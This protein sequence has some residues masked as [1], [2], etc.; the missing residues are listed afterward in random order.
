MVGESATSERAG[1]PD[2]GNWMA[3][4]II[5][6]ALFLGLIFLALSLLL[7]WLI[8]IAAVFFLISAYCQY[9]RY[10]L[11]PSGGDLQ[12]KIRSEVMDRLDWD[13]EGKALDIGC[14]AGALTVDL[15]KKYPR[16]HVTGIDQWGPNRWHYSPEMCERNA[17]LEGVGDRVVFKR[18][19][20]SALPFPDRSFDAVVSNRVFHLVTDLPDRREVIREALSVLRKGGKFSFQDLFLDKKAYGDIEELVKAIR[21]WGVRRVE[22][23]V[24]KDAPYIPRAPRLPFIIDGQAV[25][26]GEK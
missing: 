9:V 10:K 1:R 23:A 17:S 21:G 7:I 6:D 3:K 15:A 4:N 13:G 8:V 22:L 14:G 19:S 5:Y 12:A 25:I 16:A 24:T 20:A 18:A 2:Y 11:S 26:Y